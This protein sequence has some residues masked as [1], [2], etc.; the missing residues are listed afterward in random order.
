MDDLGKFASLLKNFTIENKIG[1]LHGIGLFT[2]ISNLTYNERDTI[3]TSNLKNYFMMLK[4][5]CF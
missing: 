2:F 1:T 5:S 4:I 3:Y